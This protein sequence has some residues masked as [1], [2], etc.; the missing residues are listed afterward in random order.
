MERLNWLVRL[1]ENFV[2]FINVVK[3]GAFFY[4]KMAARATFK[5]LDKWVKMCRGVWSQMLV[6]AAD[7]RTDNHT[8]TGW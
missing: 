2:E 6:S 7:T 4:L 1:T 5:C 8:D 3:C